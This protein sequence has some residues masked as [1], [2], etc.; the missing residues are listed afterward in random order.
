MRSHGFQHDVHRAR[1]QEHLVEVDVRVV[2]RAVLGL[3]RPVVLVAL[4]VC[5]VLH[6]RGFPQRVAALRLDFGAQRVGAHARDHRDHGARVH[7]GRENG[8]A[9][10]DQGAQSL[11]PRELDALDRRVPHNGADD[12]GEPV[13]LD[14]LLPRGGVLAHRRCYGFAAIRLQLLAVPVL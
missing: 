11:H 1:V 4:R 8:P 5:E 7:E 10:A 12:D 9:L 13:V 3:R 2:G 6:L 14:D